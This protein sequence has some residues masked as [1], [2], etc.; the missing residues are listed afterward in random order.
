MRIMDELRGA[1]RYRRGFM[2]TANK[3]KG[4]SFHI[5]LWVRVYFTTWSKQP[6]PRRWTVEQRNAKYIY[7][8][9]MFPLS[10]PLPTLSNQ[11]STTVINSKAS[12]DVVHFI[13]TGITILLC[14]L[15]YNYRRFVRL[16]RVNA[17]SS[18]IFC[19]DRVRGQTST[20]IPACSRWKRKQGFVLDTKRSG[21]GTLQVKRTRAVI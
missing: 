11:L 5:R 8:V 19:L 1:T 20:R 17:L 10:S 14:L 15:N 18:R 3:L 6:F 16:G 13:L 9:G 2:L 4:D 21:K 12:F 7:R